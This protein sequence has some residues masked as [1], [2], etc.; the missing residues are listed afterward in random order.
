[1][2]VNSFG[3]L[4]EVLPQVQVNFIAIIIG[5]NGSIA[6]WL[7]ALRFAVGVSYALKCAQNGNEKKN[8]LNARQTQTSEMKVKCHVRRQAK[9]VSI[10]LSLSLCLFLGLS[11]LDAL[12][13][14]CDNSTWKPLR[15]AERFMCINL[16]DF[17]LIFN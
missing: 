6:F 9:S 5:H 12:W 8:D 14:M 11:C 15:N 3:K 17:W 4:G 13:F 16:G 10:S 7:F 2:Y 1:M